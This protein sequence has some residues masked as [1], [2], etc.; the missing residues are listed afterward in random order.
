MAEVIP[1][2]VVCVLGRWLDLDTV[3]RIVSRA[4][5]DDFKLDRDFSQVSPDGR[6][7]KAFRASYARVTPSMTAE[8]WEAVR[9]HSAV[10]YMLSPPLRKDVAREISGR[11]LRV[12]AAL[13][14]DGGLAAKGES[15]GIA[16]GRA[17]WLELWDR[18][19]EAGQVGDGHREAATLYWAW[20]RR[21]LLDEEEGIYYSCGMHLLGERDIEIDSVLELEAALEWIDLLGLYLVADR[22]QRPVNDGDGFR[23]RDPGPRRV[24][25][26]RPCLRY[27]HDDFFYNP[28]GYVRLDAGTE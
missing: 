16:H 23:L 27:E 9:T 6:M 1:R 25:Q 10:A 2:H 15:A 11:V 28:Y 18:Y 17:R 5:G 12:T 3:E 13:L 26:F 14:R 24:I 21:P 8:D 19:A 20:V 7:L 22:P 4:G